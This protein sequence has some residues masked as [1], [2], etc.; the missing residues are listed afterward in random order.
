M[1]QTPCCTIHGYD[2]C[3]CRHPYLTK[4]QRINI[5]KYAYK[6]TKRYGVV[7]KTPSTYKLVPVGYRAPIQMTHGNGYGNPIR[8]SGTDGWGAT[9][10]PST[11]DNLFGSGLSNG[12]SGFSSNN[13]YYCRR[14]NCTGCDGNCPRGNLA[15]S[16][17]VDPVLGVVITSKAQYQSLIYQR[18]GNNALYC[19]GCVKNSSTDPSFINHDN[20]FMKAPPLLN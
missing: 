10:A 6:N 19:D 5:L 15:P 18:F 3:K 2:P 9:L 11:M 12:L 17:Q 7:W 1:S 8:M 4:E 14:F 20:S 16:S 13:G